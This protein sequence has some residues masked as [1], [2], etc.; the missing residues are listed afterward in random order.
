MGK[1]INRRNLLTGAA[2]TTLVTVL[3]AQASAS[4]TTVE[5]HSQR[6]VDRTALDLVVRLSDEFTFDGTALGLR[7]SL[8]SLAEKYRLTETDTSLI[9]G[10][11]RRANSEE[12]KATES[13]ALD[14]N[15]RTSPTQAT[16]SGGARLLY[17][18]HHAL[19]AG[20]GAALYA[21]AQAGPVALMAAWTAFTAAMSGP[22]AIGA[23]ILG[24]TF[25]AD[26]AVKIIGAVAQQKGIAI[27]AQ[28]GIPP[29][30]SEIE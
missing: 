26:L 25:F 30:R 24:G 1:S 7:T 20:A 22:I 28:W 23:A 4:L 10:V 13:L 18:D 9:L 8:A 14:P 29:L 12:N 5:A 21:A 11:L 15:G 6:P 27:Y 2:A 17:L 16:T 3:P 19:T